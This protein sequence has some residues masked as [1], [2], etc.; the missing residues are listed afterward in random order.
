MGWVP[1]DDNDAPA[2]VFEEARDRCVSHD[3]GGGL[4]LAGTDVIAFKGLRFNEEKEE[5][6]GHLLQ[7]FVFTLILLLLRHYI[8]SLRIRDTL[9]STGSAQT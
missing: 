4:P 6:D 3:A 5:D 7:W 9:H 1:I 2:V 8:G